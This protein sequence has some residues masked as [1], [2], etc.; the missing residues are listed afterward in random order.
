MCWVFDQKA[1]FLKDIFQNWHLFDFISTIRLEWTWPLKYEIWF[2]N[3]KDCRT[4]K[5]IDWVC[6][7]LDM[8]D[9]NSSQHSLKNWD[10]LGQYSGPWEGK[11]AVFRL[12]GGNERWSNDESMHWG[13]W[14]LKKANQQDKHSDHYWGQC[15]SKTVSDLVNFSSNWWATLHLKGILLSSAWVTL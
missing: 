6:E 8:N 3:K 13:Q 7:I 11:Q 9:I 12:A 2:Q 4:K 14:C 10:T 1:W 5:N 15:C